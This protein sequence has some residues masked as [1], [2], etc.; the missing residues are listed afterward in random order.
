MSVGVFVTNEI[1]NQF[2]F[3]MFWKKTVFS[4]VRCQSKVTFSQLVC[5]LAGLNLLYRNILH[6]NL[7]TTTATTSF[8]A[9]IY[10]FLFTSFIVWGWIVRGMNTRIWDGMYYWYGY[11][12]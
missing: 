11:S 9:Y 8:S 12:Y 5:L 6:I 2:F 10:S 3:S 7:A 1:K 4:G